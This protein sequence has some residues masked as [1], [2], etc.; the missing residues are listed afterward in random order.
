M[1]RKRRKRYK[2]KLPTGMRKRGKYYYSEL[3]VGRDRSCVALGL[4]Y[5]K[6]VRKHHEL[7]ELAERF[8]KLT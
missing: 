8:F 2:V 5:R 6:A 4:D 3:M 1:G 7:M